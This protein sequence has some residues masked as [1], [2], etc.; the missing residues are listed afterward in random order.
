[1]SSILKALRR[2]EE[3]RARKS[4][5][6]PEI[7]ASL[8]RSGVRRRSP[9]PWIWPAVI[10]AVAAL[11]AALLWSWRPAP[12]ANQIVTPI[13]SP[14]TISRAVTAGRGGEIIIEEVMDQRRPVLLPPVHSQVVSVPAPLPV[15]INQ[16]PQGAET[17]ISTP[18]KTNK[19][20]TAFIEKRQNPVVSAI[21]WQEDSSARMAVVDGLPVMTGESVGTAR[22]QEILRDHILFTEAGM[23]FTVYVDPQ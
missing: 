7:A 14:P 9:S 10:T 12:L 16:P 23:L 22:V 4:H 21:A 5:A 11:A 8:L 17:G 2:L 15:E 3:E 19:P 20:A 18:S 6:A 1:M 13:A